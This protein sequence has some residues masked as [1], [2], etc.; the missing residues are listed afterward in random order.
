MKPRIALLSLALAAGTAAVSGEVAAQQVRTLPD[1]RWCQDDGHRDGERYCEVRE[2][3]L[4]ADRERISVDAEPNGGIRVEAWDRGE[5]LVRARVQ[6]QA[7]SASAAREMVREV[8]VQTA[9]TIRGAGPKAGRREW[10]SVSY[11]LFVPRR[12]NLDLRSKNGGI[13][14]ESVAGAIEFQTTNGGLELIDLK[15]DVRGSTTNGNVHIALGGREW[16]GEGLDVRTTNGGVKIDIP[17]DYS[18][19]LESG[20][21]NGS[22]QVDFPLTVRGRID[23][24]IEAELGSGGKLIRALTTNGSVAIRRS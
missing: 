15:G 12:S 4:A 3:A 11:E 22:F 21:V 1:D 17:D 13:S 19:R 5:I 18:A 16:E 9:G 6:A 7:R 10:W 2:V 14:I 20:T 24:R 23:R 8:T